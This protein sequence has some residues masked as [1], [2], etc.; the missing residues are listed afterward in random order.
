MN[1]IAAGLFH[2]TTF[3]EGIGHEVSSYYVEPSATL[4]DPMVPEDGL[5]WFSGRNVHRVVLTNRHHYRQADRFAERFEIPVLVDVVGLPDVQDRPGVKDFGWDEQV[6]PD[7]TAHAVDPVWPDEGALHIALGKGW[8]ALADGAMHYA[9]EI[10]TVPDS[11]LGDD[12]A[13]TK[14]LLRT[15][16]G[17]LLDLDFDGILFAHGTPITEGGKDSLRAFVDGQ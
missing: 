5:D 8:L 2:W 10:H 17:R 4:L 3:H 13:R 1:E 7:I 6:A 11:L 9:D 14:D 12:P 15:G 16:Y